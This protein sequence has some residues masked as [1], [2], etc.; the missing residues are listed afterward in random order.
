MSVKAQ[1]GVLAIDVGTSRVK[2]G[3]FPSDVVCISDK[4]AG[5]LP[6]SAPPLPEPVETFA[7]QHRGVPEDE[8]VAQLIKSLE[9]FD[10]LWTSVAVAS[11]DADAFRKVFD[12][13]K[14][15]RRLAVPRMLEVLGLPIKLAIR[16]PHRVGIDRVL[17]ALNVTI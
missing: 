4:Q 12:V 16:Q 7:I 2:V 8:F 1:S 9:P 15:C 5:L 11:V 14:K 3:W 13:L 17:A 6:I 10:E